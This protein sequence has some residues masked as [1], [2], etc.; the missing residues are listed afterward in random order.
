MPKPK[1]K[2]A[3]EPELAKQW[4]KRLEED[5]E[6]PPQI[7]EKDH[8]DVRTVRKQI[9]KVR[10]EREKREAR[11]TVFRNALEEHHNDLVSFAGKI[12]EEVSR[13]SISS[14]TKL[15]RLYRA[16]RQ[17]LPRSPLWK[18]IGRLDDMS[19]EVITLRRQLEEKLQVKVRAEIVGVE[20]TEIFPDSI[21]GAVILRLEIQKEELLPTLKRNPIHEGK[22][23]IRYGPW[24]CAIGPNV[25][26]P[27]VEKF[28]SDLIAQA[29]ESPESAN[30]RQLLDQRRKVIE[31]IREE[32]A[33]IKLRRLVP[34]QCK[35]CPIY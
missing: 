28:V 22:T 2:P 4:L 23:E 1:N 6:T 8:Y 27:A 5:G 34:G 3:V 13:F 10:Q 19:G 14:S 9:E 15:G 35:Y 7:A 11:L 25:Q 20:K 32:L 33:T 17:H 30:M 12:D 26:I 18:A 29:S 24:N 21:A 31:T 16:L